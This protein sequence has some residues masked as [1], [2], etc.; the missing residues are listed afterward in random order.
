VK[1]AVKVGLTDGQRTQVTGKDISA[2][3]SIVIGSSDGATATTAASSNPL[4]PTAPRGGGRGGP[5]AF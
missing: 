1:H 3:D 4:Q 2:G 5:G